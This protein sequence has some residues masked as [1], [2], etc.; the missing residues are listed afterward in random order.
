MNLQ[1]VPIDNGFIVIVNN[2]DGTASQNAFLDP[3]GV[4]AYV[5]QVLGIYGGVVS[6]TSTE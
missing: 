3:K 4:V 2:G 6:A 5:A 1:I